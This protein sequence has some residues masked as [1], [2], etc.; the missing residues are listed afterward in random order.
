M[1]T[2]RQQKGAGE[3][4]VYLRPEPGLWTV[5]FYDPEGYYHPESD[6]DNHEEAAARVHYLNG[7]NV[8]DA[9]PEKRTWIKTVDYFPQD[10]GGK[11]DE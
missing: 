4:Y 11:L 6:H 8:I 1:R 3:M 7:G 2:A 5:G 9:L 10:G